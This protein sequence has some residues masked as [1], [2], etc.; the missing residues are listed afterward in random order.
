MSP[1]GSCGV[2]DPKGQSSYQTLGLREDK[3]NLCG[4][5][6]KCKFF[7]SVNLSACPPSAYSQLV[8]LS[9]PVCIPVCL[10]AGVF[11]GNRLDLTQERLEAIHTYQVCP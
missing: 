1:V 6:S 3:L 2:N 7:L 8:S 9:Q 10:L 4:S 5:E 11:A